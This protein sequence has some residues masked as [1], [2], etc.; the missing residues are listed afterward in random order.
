MDWIAFLYPICVR[1][2]ESTISQIRAMWSVEPE[3]TS[4]IWRDSYGMNLVL[5]VRTWREKQYKKENELKNDNFQN[6]NLS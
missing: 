5:R 2:K 1:C 3:T 4:A 6:L